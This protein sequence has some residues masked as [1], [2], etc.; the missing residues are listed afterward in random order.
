ML[1]LFVQFEHVR[2]YYVLEYLRQF[3]FHFPRISQFHVAH[4]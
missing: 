1:D 4:N 3:L 2:S